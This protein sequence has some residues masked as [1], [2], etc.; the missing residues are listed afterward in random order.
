MKE[1]LLWV[2][3]FD[4]VDELRLTPVNFKEEYSREWIIG[5]HGYKTLSVVQD[6]QKEA[7]IEAV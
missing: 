3:R 5:R 2:R 4:V 7:M 6:F 1:N